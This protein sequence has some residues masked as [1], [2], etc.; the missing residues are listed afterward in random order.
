M[1]SGGVPGAGSGGAV[2]TGGSAVVGAAAAGG[3]AAGSTGGA[4]TS[5]G[6]SGAA[7]AQGTGATPYTL[8]ITIGSVAP[9]EENTQCIQQRLSNTAPIEVNKLHNVLS[10]GS[11]H[12]IVSALT[13]AGAD[14]APLT[15]CK[16]FQGALT[17]EPLAITQKKDDTVVTPDGV[18]YALAASQVVHLELHYINTTTD[19]LNVSAQ[20][21][22]SAA[23]AGAG[24]QEASVLLIGTLN[25]SIPAMAAASTGPRFIAMPSQVDGVSYYAITGH[26]HRMG[27]SVQVSSASANGASPTVVYAPMPYDWDAPELKE[28]SPAMHLPTGG[29]FTLQC[30]WQNTSNSALA[31]GESALN[32]MCF[33]WAYYYPKKT[34]SNLI[35]DGFGAV[36]PSLILGK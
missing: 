1:A 5:A 13:A 14:V 23:A 8:S 7:G 22:I 9:G 20:T 6:G 32:E 17:G 15:P 27:K 12:F 33:F 34:I 31:F 19:T 2:S 29:G 4:A 18:G 16:P 36:D 25:I 35:I 28:F 3:A 24:L 30:D 21:E 26:T 10:N 11:H